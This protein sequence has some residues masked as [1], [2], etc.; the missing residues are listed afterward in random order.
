MIEKAYAKLYGSYS[1]ICSGQLAL[2]LAD[3]NFGGYPEKIFLKTM[4]SNAAT[5]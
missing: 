5:F 3:L 4:N 2:A 1:N